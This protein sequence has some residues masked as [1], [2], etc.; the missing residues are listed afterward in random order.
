MTDGLLK[1]SFGG[2]LMCLQAQNEAVMRKYGR[3]DYDETLSA[4]KPLF[5]DSDY[6]IANLETPLSEAGLSEE[7]ICFNTPASFADAIKKAGIHFVQTAN[8]HC[9]DRG[10]EG[11]EQTLAVLDSIGLEHSGTYRTLE[12]SD[13]LFVKEIAGVKVAIICCTFGTNSE[14]NGHILPV[15][16]TWRVD[17]LKRQNKL[18]MVASRVSDAPIIS[19]MIP[20]NVSVAAITNSAN[21][22]YTERIKEKILRAKKEADIVIVLPH[23]GGQYNPAPGAWSKWTVDWMSQ[24]QPSLIVAGHPHVPLRTENVNG[25][26]TAWSLG[27]LSFTPGVGY[28]LPNVLADYGVVLHAWFEVDSK[29]LVKAGFNLIKNVVGE[30]GISRIKPVFDLWNESK[31]AI[32]R[33]CLTIDNEALV[34]RLRGGAESVEV[35]NEYLVNDITC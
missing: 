31:N 35:K 14:H 12:D 15:D 8:N 20:D 11:M 4:L 9:L 5:A 21:V 7:Q 18:S 10:V 23:I 2:D 32:E 1:I 3:Y 24:L 16:E 33:D 34:N 6:V 17:L 28:Y 30:D 13:R 27:N 25:V 26:F 29:K 22:A 19:S